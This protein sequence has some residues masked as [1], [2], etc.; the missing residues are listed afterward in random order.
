MPVALLSCGLW[1]AASAPYAEQVEFSPTV[2]E[3]PLRPSLVYPPHGYALDV[4]HARHVE[5]MACVD[6]H[7]GVEDSTD[8]RQAHLPRMEDCAQCHSEAGDVQTPGACSICHDG[9]EP[10]WP[11]AE[12]IF[13][14]RDPRF[15]MVSPEASV[16]FLPNLRFSHAAHA[17]TPC[18]LCHDE[19]R[20]GGASLPDETVCAGCHATEVA[21]DCAFCHTTEDDGRLTTHLPGNRL[22]APQVLRPRNHDSAWPTAHGVEAQL[23]TSECLSCHLENDCM[24]CH[25]ATLGAVVSHPPGFRSHHGVDARRGGTDCTSCHMSTGFCVDCH[26]DTRVADGAA[27][28]DPQR[29][30]FHASAWVESAGGEHARAAQLNMMECASCHQESTCAACHVDVNPHGA[31]FIGRCRELWERRPNMCAR[32]HAPDQIDEL[33]RHCL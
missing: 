13:T 7:G 18:G 28:P 30:R 31:D 26:V 12:G 22:V 32:C 17:D 25:Q 8:S 11:P 16:P 27:H 5:S 21:S 15:P 1:A 3:A 23:N 6:C 9:Y 19:A 20:D 24:G 29:G 10:V 14:T 2:A 4:A 33:G